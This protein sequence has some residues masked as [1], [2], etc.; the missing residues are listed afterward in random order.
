MN[1]EDMRDRS[2]HSLANRPYAKAD[3]RGGTYEG[4]ECTR[5]LCAVVLCEC[6]DMRMDRLSAHG[7]S[8]LSIFA[9]SGLSRWIAQFSVNNVSSHQTLS[10]TG[11]VSQLQWSCAGIGKELHANFQGNPA[12]EEFYYPLPKR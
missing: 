7:P 4:V 10:A 9:S 5:S 12:R 8:M 2:N 3:S 1:G 11:F 6:R